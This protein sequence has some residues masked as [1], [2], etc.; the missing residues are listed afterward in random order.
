MSIRIYRKS[1][2][3]VSTL[4][5]LQIGQ[6][7]IIKDT[8]DS[9]KY[10]LVVGTDTGNI[11]VGGQGFGGGSG[12]TDHSLLTGLSN[13]DHPQY[14]NTTR[15][16]IRYYTKTLLDAG[17]LDNR[18]FTES[19]VT[20]LL[21]GKANSTHT[22]VSTDITDFQTAVT[23]N[24][25]VSANTTA[26][27]SHTNKALLDTYT[28]TEV[29]LADAV[30]K[31][32]T[33]LNLT[34]LDLVSGTNTGDETTA[35][36]K[37]KL[38]I[39]TLSGSNTGDQ[40]LSGLMVKS[41][42]LSDVTNAATARTNLGVAIGTN[43]QA[44]DATLA[45]LAA[46]TTTGSGSIVL[47]TNPTI[48]AP[49]INKLSNLTT[50]GFV[51][52]S[53][54]D[55]TLSI[56]TNTYLTGNQSITLSGDISGTG[57]TAITTV[58]GAGKVTNAMLAGSIDLATKVTGN[59]PIANLNG[60]TSA[61]ST[62][63]WRG[64][65][66]W[67]APA[68]GGDMLLGTVQTITASK[69]FN[70]N[71]LWDKGNHVF[72]VKAYGAIGNDTA[73]D[74]TAIQSAIDAARLVGGIVW[75]PAGTYK[76]TATLKLYTGTTPTITAYSNITLA[77][78]GSSGAGGSIIKQYTTG[79]DCIKGINDV[80]N[81]AQ[82]LNITIQDLNLAWGTAT[83]TN[84]GNGLYLSQ[85]A[86]GG[87]SYQQFNIKNVTATNFQGS[88]KYGF[89]MES[90]I[91]STLDTCMAV[92]CSN[93]FYLNG[94]VGSA[95]GS[96]S[97]SV[98]FINC[99]ANM[100]TNGV[101]GFN[102]LDNTYISFVGCAVDIGANT[103]GTAYLVDGSNC[104]SFQGCGVEL[105]GTVTLTNMWK[106]NASSQ[107]GLY[108]C[109]GFQAKT[110]NLIYATGTSTGITV[111]GFQENSTISGSTSV[112]TDAGSQISEL[113][114]LFSSAKSNAGT[115]TVI[116]TGGSGDMV[117]ASVQTVT[118]AKTFND[119]KLI[120]A[121][122]TSGTT[123]LKSGAAAGT[124]VITLPVATDTLVGKATTDTFTN[125]S[126]SGATN[127]LSAIGLSSLSATGTPSATTYLRG[128]NT[129]ATP[130]GS[131]TVTS[132]TS[133]NSDISIATT[134]TTPV[135]TLNSSST[136]TASK[137]VLRDSNAI[138]YAT[139]IIQSTSTNA[140][141]GA[142]ATLNWNNGANQRLTLT[143]NCT[144][145]FSNPVAGAKYTI[146]LIQDVTGTRTVTF[147]TIKWASGS[148][149]VLTT[150]AAKV[151]IISLYYNGTDYFGTYSLNF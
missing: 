107:I 48:T 35:T 97:T 151:D 110:T 45:G 78:A 60:G 54:G 128:D 36:I 116:G 140:T 71:T 34:S 7:A 113:D 62:T 64:D 111:I 9:N 125:K 94:A 131:G 137:V 22:H 127:T 123:T 145:T 40:D 58:I 67:A 83:K 44:Y 129:W 51:K 89:N 118:G 135:L 2:A 109:Y 112:K 141:S 55:G 82:S 66:V 42:N 136:A 3:G 6:L 108:N 4:Q 85:Q 87:P 146:E 142:A 68:G 41:N 86:A 143:A 46:K 106:F 79:V 19:E 84:S 92:S 124:S 15:G 90:I 21:A 17:Q 114:C 43:V 31:K 39:T 73:D 138:I 52:T 105:S 104:V 33:H 32:H 61:S 59:L 139:S 121:G 119:A 72:D 13:D 88:G 5:A 117:L 81:G 25:N 30:S 70:A 56:D 148:A 49:S 98:S 126:I 80:A 96:V 75:F 50:N 93:S 28:Q 115:D 38:G 130:A 14:F 122:V 26:R 27:H 102:I 47:A 24:T 91:V 37:T 20:T 101:I 76:I 63:F 65:G 1:V 74:T 120:L 132:V 95:Y 23:N 11:Q 134:T 8:S 12:V 99:Y 29:N 147:P 100:A 57:T 144:L 69:T 103:T 133:A 150:T 77:G 16:D 53:A 10:K 149:P 18:Y